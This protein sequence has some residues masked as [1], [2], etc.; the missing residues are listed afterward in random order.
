MSII[1]SQFTTIFGDRREYSRRTFKFE[2]RH[3]TREPETPKGRFEGELSSKRNRDF[4]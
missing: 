1:K 3:F 2:E 4:S